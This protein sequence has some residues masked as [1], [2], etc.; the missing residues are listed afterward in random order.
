MIGDGGHA[1][2]LRDVIESIRDYSISL[3]GRI[4]IGYII[5]DTRQVSDEQLKSLSLNFAGYILG[6]G[7]IYNSETR[8]K[9]VSRIEAS[10]GKI[11]TL[12]SPYARVSPRAKIGKGTVVM[13]GACVNTGA[14]VEGYCIVNTGSNVEHDAFVGEHTHIATGA[15]VN[16]DC[17]VGQDCFIGSNSVLLNQMRICNDTLVG[18]GSVVTKNIVKPGGIYVG[19]PATLLRVRDNR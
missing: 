3:G 13:H 17:S 4:Q 11:I 9:I 5:K 1:A 10:G 16:G 12:I 14:R 15:V 18:A 2:A 6:V 8:R 19:N 7:K